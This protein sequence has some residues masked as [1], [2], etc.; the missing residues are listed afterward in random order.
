L[1]KILLSIVPTKINE[2]LKKIKIFR[3]NKRLW[4]LRFWPVRNYSRHL[5]YYNA[6]LNFKIDEI[7]NEKLKKKSR[8]LTK[9][10]K[11]KRKIEVS[12]VCFYF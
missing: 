2:K 5:S 4:C 9:M 7:W 8:E 6:R 11:R 1:R 12:D 10:R 3:T